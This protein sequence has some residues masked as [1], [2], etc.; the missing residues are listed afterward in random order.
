MRILLYGDVD[1]SLPGGLETHLRRLALGLG[2]R[3]HN[4]EIYGRPAVLAPFRMVSA[5][6]PKRYDIVHHHG[7]AW[8]RGLDVGRRYVRTLHF[9]TAAKMLNYVRLGR[10]RTLAHPGNW[11]GVAEEGASAR[12][13]GALIAV[14]AR[15]VRDFQRW[16]GLDPTRAVVIPNGATFE[17]PPES[18]VAI[19]ARF[20][21]PPGAS[22]LLTIGRADFVKGHGLLER[23]WIAARPPDA[24]WVGVGG[25]AARR[26]PGRIITGP[27]P[28]EE[29]VSWIHAADVAAMPS[30]YEGCSVAMLEMLAGNV[31]VLAHDVGNADEVIRDGDNGRIVAPEVRA[32]SA[33]LADT[34]SHR[35]RGSGLDMRFRWEHIVEQ[36]EAVYAGVVRGS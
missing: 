8:P 25:D 34:L 22:V 6:E 2:A 1:L 12:R 3:G 31:F 19:R 29:V 15:V 28:H 18:R 20:G 36:T 27:L 16:Y 5:V 7:G 32:W 24:V 35:P 14:A 4:V 17:T 33:A 26:E 9:C 11:R 21:V 10:L 23:A 13:P 30:Y